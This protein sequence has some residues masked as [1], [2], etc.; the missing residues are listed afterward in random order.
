MKLKLNLEF[1]TKLNKLYRQ[2]KIKYGIEFLDLK[3]NELLQYCLSNDLHNAK[4]LFSK[5]KGFLV[6]T[7]KRI[8]L[9]LFIAMLTK[10]LPDF[11]E[12]STT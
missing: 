3:Y 10:S 2:K 9:V 1:E 11:A 6:S 5:Y 4:K 12:N 8:I 7:T